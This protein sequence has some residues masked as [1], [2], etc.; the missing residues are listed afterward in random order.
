MLCY[1]SVFSVLGLSELLLDLQDCFIRNLHFLSMFSAGEGWFKLVWRW[2]F[3][4]RVQFVCRCNKSWTCAKSWWE[5]RHFSTADLLY[6]FFLWSQLFHF[7][8]IALI[9]EFRKMFSWRLSWVAE[10][11]LFMVVVLPAVASPPTVKSD[12]DHGISNHE[13]FH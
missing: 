9:F 2:Y 13:V 8:C 10:G 3:R 11:P 1:I 4:R 5:P 12:W 7:S 6:Y